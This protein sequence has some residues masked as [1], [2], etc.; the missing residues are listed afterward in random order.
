MINHTRTPLGLPGPM[1]EAR[2][3]LRENWI[4]ET[5]TITTNH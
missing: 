5:H 4:N 2:I 1:S 3:N